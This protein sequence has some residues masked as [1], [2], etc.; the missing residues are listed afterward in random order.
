MEPL[1]ITNSQI[2]ISVLIEGNNNL[3]IKKKSLQYDKK[4]KWLPFRERFLQLT[5]KPLY[6]NYAF[7][8]NISPPPSFVSCGSYLEFFYC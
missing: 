1:K 3:Q 7:V 8:R 2:T 5:I 4:K 6:E